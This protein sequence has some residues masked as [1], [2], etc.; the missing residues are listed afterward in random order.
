MISSLAVL[1]G[2]DRWQGGPARPGPGLADKLA[3][4]AA[5][6]PALAPPGGKGAGPAE[7]RRSLARVAGRVLVSADLD[8]DGAVDARELFEARTHAT[9]A[10]VTE[11]MDEDR[12]G[13]VC[14]AE[15]L[16]ANERRVQSVMEAFDTDG[17]GRVTREEFVRVALERLS[18][19][20][21]D[22]DGRFTRE[23]LAR[24]PSGAVPRRMASSRQIAVMICGPTCVWLMGDT[25]SGGPGERPHGYCE[26]HPD[27]GWCP[28]ATH[29]GCS[30]D[31]VS[32]GNCVCMWPG[33]CA[34]FFD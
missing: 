29:P 25:S 34:P 11:D 28:S 1:F 33:Y 26:D 20:D 10:L 12:D 6:N 14:R 5:R 8:G 9:G 4:M 17:D 22:G 18:G 24:R 16:A 19:L 2:C 32:T 13:A 7:L 27:A 31:D 30:N 23:E 21:V 15:F 3:A